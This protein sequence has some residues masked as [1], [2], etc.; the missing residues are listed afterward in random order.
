MVRGG[1]ESITAHYAITIRDRF[2]IPTMDK[3][4][5]KLHGAQIF[6]KLD[7]RASYHQIRIVE[8]DIHKLSFRTHHGH[9]EFTVMPFGLINAPAT[10]QATMNQ[11]LAEFLRKFVVVFFDDILIYS[12]SV[13]EHF[14]HL[15]KVFERLETQLFFIRRSKCSFGVEE[16]EYLEH[17][18]TTQGV[19]PDPAKVAAVE[20]WPVPKT[21]R[22]VRAFLGLTGYYRRFIRQY[23]QVAAPITNLLRKNQFKWNEEATQAFIELKQILTSAPVLVYPDFQIPFTVETMLVT[24]ESEPFYYN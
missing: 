4:V 14:T 15:R 24:L 13:E 19:R 8:G 21:V 20:S 10:F 16:L 6:S 2:P 5:D 22:Q 12:K 9:Y 1:F 18:I 7:L 3:L 11:F 23:A 17:I